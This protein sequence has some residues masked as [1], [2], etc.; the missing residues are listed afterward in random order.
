M[1]NILLVGPLNKE[2]VGGRLEEMKL[3]AKLLN[4]PAIHLEVFTPNFSGNY[5][6]GISC[7]ET[8]DLKFPGA[9]SKGRLRKMLLRIWYSQLFKNSRDRFYQSITW[10]NFAEK[11][12]EIFLFITDDSKERIIFESDLKNH[13][14]LRYTGTVSNFSRINNDSSLIKNTDLRSYIFHSTSLLQGNSPEISTVFIDQTAILEEKLLKIPIS[15]E[16]MTFGMVG[17]FMEVKQVEGVIRVFEKFPS[18]Q[19]L[20]FGQGEL[21][22]RYLE[23][24][25]ELN[26][27]N[28]QIL[29][30]VSPDQI[31]EIY[32]KIDVLIINSEHETGPMTG[33]EAMASG[34]LI[35]SRPIGAMPSRL[36][37]FPDLI[38]DSDRDLEKKIKL[39]SSLP[40]SSVESIKNRIR[41]VYKKEFSLLILESQLQALVS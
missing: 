33:V 41:E 6:G 28:I 37:G 5:F 15:G 27:T 7:K 3:W 10:R 12:D 23:L 14:Y 19:L 39:I 25:H 24:I 30:F 32:K 36:K 31:D 1:K 34:K 2:G 20:L 4:G 38:Y 35:L 11:F 13:V 29:D 9:W 18:L 17:L 40:L 8:F 21:K 26:L 22:P 16:A